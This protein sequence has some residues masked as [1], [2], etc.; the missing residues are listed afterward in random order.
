MKK[1]SRAGKSLVFSC[2]VYFV[3]YTIIIVLVYFGFAHLANQKINEA[4]FTIEDLRSYKED[5]IHENYA[6]LPVKNSKTSAIIIFD[7]NGTIKYASNQSISEKVFFQDLDMVDDYNSSNFFEVLE[8][9]E[10]DGS[11]EYTVYLNG[12]EKGSMVPQILNYCI[13][14]EE[15]RIVEGELF[16]DREFL[17]QREF[18]LLSGIS[19]L[20]GTLTKYVYKNANGEERI[21]A[22]LSTSISDKQY[23]R[24]MDSINIIGIIGILS[25]FLVILVFAVL[26]FRRIQRRI[27]PLNQTIASYQNG[28]A[29]EI[30]PSAVPSE[31]RETVCSFK[32]LVEELEHTREENET[33]YKEKQKLIVD[34]SHDLKTP[35]TVIQ[36]YA[37]ALSEGRVPDEKKGAYVDSIFNKSKMA[38]DMVNDLFMFTQMEHPDYQLHLEETDFNEFVKSFFAEK[39]MEIAEGGFQLSADM[40]DTPIHLMLDRRLIRRLL[41]NLLSNAIKYNKKGTTIYISMDKRGSDAVLTIADDGIGIPEDIAQSL[42]Q[43]FVTGNHARTTGKGTGLGLSIAQRIVQMHRGRMELVC[44]PHKPY[45]TEFCIQLPIPKNE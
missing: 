35:L 23:A 2:A 24:I 3:C 29:A 21:L 37:K 11:T 1:I 17:T 20:N 9:V 33:L 22:F 31:F 45:H 36:G 12:Y 28:K 13:L 32:N 10:E 19:R 8:N 7:E 27:S 16:S 4:V 38:A 14:D 25:A 39:Y 43:P 5:L 41:E 44:P 30:D 18:E 26:F 15:Y 40:E 34:I 42:F 6:R